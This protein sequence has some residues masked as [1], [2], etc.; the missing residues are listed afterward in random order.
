MSFTFRNLFSEE[1]EGVPGSNGDR[2]SQPGEPNRGQ[3]GSGAGAQ[4]PAMQNF[5]VSEL[6]PFIPPAISAESGIPM[7]KMVAIPMPPNGSGDLALST[8]YQ[9]VPE[10][11][12]AEIT[13]LNDSKVTLPVKIAEPE[14]QPAGEKKRVSGSIFEGPGQTAASP[15]GGLYAA[16][17]EAA[18]KVPEESGEDNPFW[19]P[20]NSDAPE[21]SAAAISAG[22]PPAIPAQVATVKAK[23]EVEGFS[24]SEAATREAAIAPGTGVPDG[25]NSAVFGSS[26]NIAADPSTDEEEMVPGAG[27]VDGAMPAGFDTPSAK[28]QGE[29][30]GDD[31]SKSETGSTGFGKGSNPFA[32]FTPP[33]SLPVSEQP[34]TPGVPSDGTP[35]G[36]TGGPTGENPFESGDDFSTLFSKQAE[37]D[38]D[39]PFPYPEGESG[40]SWGAMF[41]SDPK[42]EEAPVESST[43]EL[44]KMEPGF[45]NMIKQLGSSVAAPVAKA[46]EEAPAMPPRTETAAVAEPK[47]EEPAPPEF[48]P[49]KAAAD[50]GGFEGF[51]KA[52]PSQSVQR[53]ADPPAEPP[54]ALEEPVEVPPEAIE[55]PSVEE[56]A[57]EPSEELSSVMSGF[58]AFPDPDPV[59]EPPSASFEETSG[60]VWGEKSLETPDVHDDLGIVEAKK[61]AE[62]E[63]T[64][65]PPAEPRGPVSLTPLQGA[66]E[67]NYRDLEF[68]AIFS[69]DETF[70]L[71][72]VARRVIN[73]QGIHGCALA[74][75]SRMVQA[76]R[77][78]Q[79]RLQDE[80]REMVGTIRSLAKLT[81]LPEARS[82]T[83][84]TDQGTVSLFLEG[85]CCVSVHHDSAA[86]GP[87]VK[88]K[89]IL[90]A[91]SIHKLEE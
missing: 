87:G 18:V 5:Q 49:P 12:A 24:T 45:G 73:L 27:K 83:L 50:T 11:F 31:L 42:A 75:P 77:N 6:L 4:A 26:G 72:R 39:I 67:T 76:S 8:L 58:A 78:E 74:T 33:E 51:E 52:S 46:E 66:S 79:S 13:P 28:G 9:I 19:S 90:I 17:S 2:N 82:F 47:T 65:L 59:E 70:T 29:P 44:P 14:M 34:G 61:G 89:L 43:V 84:Q 91:R 21:S 23:A 69:S 48:V 32:D 56:K 55:L 3:P 57:P 53:Q 35:G 80:A 88:E 25:G 36:E 54:A 38:G 16:S 86:F 15:S 37:E 40:E 10:L 41:D 7:G 68:R 71:S 22:G 63:E 60:D 30:T 1:E 62:T 64:Q 81:G 85:D 20:G